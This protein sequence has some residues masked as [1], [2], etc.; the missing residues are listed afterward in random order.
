MVDPSCRPAPNLCECAAPNRLRSKNASL[1]GNLRK[2]NQAL[3]EKIR[4]KII[5]NGHFECTSVFPAVLRMN[6][7]TALNPRAVDIHEFQSS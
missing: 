1:L 6:S 4:K 7:A 5:H 2:T 3:T